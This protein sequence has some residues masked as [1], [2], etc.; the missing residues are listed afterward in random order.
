MIKS[1]KILIFSTAY[2]PF[3]GGA[4]IAIKEITDRINDLEFDLITAKLKRG[5]PNFEKVG[6]VNIYRVGVGLQTFD[7]LTLPFLGAIKALIL[8]RKNKYRAFWCM[9]VS[10]ASGAAYVS[11]IVR[12]WKKVPIILTLQ[13]GDSEEHFSR[14]WFGLINL[15]WRLALSCADKLTV[16]SNYL[17]ERA[18]KLGYKGE[19]ALIPNG[20]SLTRF[21]K[22]NTSYEKE[23]R[24]KIRNELGLKN[25]DIAL[26]TTSRLTLK[27]GIGDVIEALKLL[28]GNVKFVIIG[29]GELRESLELLASNLG[30]EDRVV[31]KGF[32][33]HEELPKYL[34]ACDI[35]IRP[36]LSEGM[37]ISFIEA[38]AAGIP[39]IATPVGGIVDFLKDFSSQKY[40]GPSTQ[41][42]YFCEPQN[43]QSIASTIKKVISDENKTK[44][45][46]KAQEL[47]K[48]KYDWQ[49]IAE[50]MDK[51]IED[52]K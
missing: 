3:W 39:V 11:N 50:E 52:I 15:S 24:Q 44:V 9:M 29:T 5:L 17:N 16:I 10:F 12:F 27:N 28:P 8:D 35:F 26:I 51:V 43:P 38:M 1:K 36:S 46:S 21:E 13:E 49:L 34:K 20:V 18:R 40:D 7:K 32:I 23:E 47:V 33:A 25:E 37:G 41:T 2:A 19:V 31:F 14:R 6:R 45:I 22:R 48:E 30:V 4:E 42:G